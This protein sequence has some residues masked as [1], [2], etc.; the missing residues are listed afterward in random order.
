MQRRDFLK[1]KVYKRSYSDYDEP[2]TKTVKKTVSFSD[3]LTQDIHT[4]AFD[5]NGDETNSTSPIVISSKI[6]RPS[7]ASAYTQRDQLP[8]SVPKIHHETT[9]IS[10]PPPEL[11]VSSSI[12]A[13]S[14]QCDSTLTASAVSPLVN[15]TQAASAQYSATLTASTVPPTLSSIVASSTQLSTSISASSDP[16]LVPPSQTKSITNYFKVTSRKVFSPSDKSKI[17]IKKRTKTNN[18]FFF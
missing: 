5:E 16:F 10:D 8:S 11:S 1:T 7:L 18:K 4:P 9:P 12:G 6:D 3:Q 17:S 2:S 15:Q 14:A 13:A